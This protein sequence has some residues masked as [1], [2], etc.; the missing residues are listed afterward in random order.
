MLA[1]APLRHHPFK[2]APSRFYLAGAEPTMVDDTAPLAEVSNRVHGGLMPDCPATVKGG[3][4]LAMPLGSKNATPAKPANR[5]FGPAHQS[6]AART[7]VPARS[8]PPDLG[9]TKLS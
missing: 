9:I 6:D 1:A 3:A 8:N 7:L 5:R 2:P 4:R